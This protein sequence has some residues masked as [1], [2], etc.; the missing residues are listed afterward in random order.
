MI[1]KNVLILSITSFVDVCPVSERKGKNLLLK[2]DVLGETL[3]K[4]HYLD[5]ALVCLGFYNK[6]IIDW[7]A[8]TA[9]IYF[10]QFWRLRKP[11]S[12]YMQIQC[13]VRTSLLVP[14]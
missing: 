8:Y 10:S 5:I 14:R 4:T 3:G 9:N 12:K 7:L 11:R 6:N 13:L 2:G 1:F